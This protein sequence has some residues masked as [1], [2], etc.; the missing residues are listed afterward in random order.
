MNQQNQPSPYFIR[1]TTPLE[2]LREGEYQHNF[3]EEDEG[4]IDFQ[5]YWRIIRKHLGLIAAVVATAVVLTTLHELMQTPMYTAEATIL[6]KPGTP[7]ILGSQSQTGDSPSVDQYEYYENFNATQFEILKSRSLAE[8]AIKS[9]G[10]EK[11]LLPDEFAAPSAAGE[12]WTKSALD[13]L[14]KSL[15]LSEDEAPAPPRPQHV[16]NSSGVN[17]DAISA[18]LG[19]LS[20]RPVPDTDLAKIA[21]TTPDPKLSAELANAHA[22]A[23]IRQ[24]IELHSQANEEAQKFLQ[25]KL[26][27]LKEQLQK[28]EYALNR[29][30]RDQGIVPGL[31]SLDGKETVVLD[32]LSD[33]SK[34]LTKAQV[35]RIDL[36]SK[37]QMV[38]N[39]QYDALPEMLDDKALQTLREQYDALN[40]EYAGMAK[41]FKPDYPPLARLQAKRDQ[42]QQDIDQEEHR[43]ASAVESQYDEARARETDLQSEME[44]SRNKALGLND[45]AVEYA[46]LQRE[47]DTN[48]DL[49][50]S[51]LQR[52]KDVGL[53]SQARASNIVIVDDAEVPHFRSS[54]LIKQS[55]M[56]AAVLSLAGG[57]GLAFVLEF[58]NNRIKTPEE[59]EQY[60]KLPNLAVVPEFSALGDRR[61]RNAAAN[62][63]ERVRRL[64]IGD[65]LPDK[66]HP[67]DLIGAS[68]PYSLHGEAYRTLRTGLL[69]S[70]AGSPPRII[71]MTST[72]SGEG[73]TATSTNSAVLFAHT[74]ARVLLIDGDLRKPRCHRVF[75][76]DKE[77]GLTEAL[78]GRREVREL[79]RPTH[80]DGLSILTSGSLPPNPTELLGSEK[81]RQLL[82]QLAQDYDFVIIDSPPVLP[83]SDAIILST[84]VDGV[85]VVVN[86]EA[87]AKQQVRI[88]CARLRYARA[89]IFGAVLNKVN[90]MSPEYRYYSSYYYQ[91]TNEVLQGSP[92]VQARNSENAR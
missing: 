18:Y 68:N 12:S 10:L 16:A 26:V 72:T 45:A 59:L 32:R 15:G 80:V 43:V 73:K 92:E 23:Y 81:M 44:T 79:I 84:L 82:A 25:N 24:G 48:R 64:A 49:Y 20:I 7:Q 89:K 70:R 67:K 4:R 77:P 55:V 53:A 51:V 78:T 6:I 76:L 83:V 61:R 22:H 58:F 31:M 34:D 9:G 88:A 36:E 1:R 47:V 28:S 19:G 42:L 46:I 5:Q 66:S 13:W 69:Y 87:T 85:V 62:Q 39:H 27:D 71:L 17:P 63:L 2:E 54:P 3:L 29:Y 90:V 52:M 40:T 37:V 33:L 14:R 74:G 11:D 35:D 86:S 60:L 56:T 75:D 8:E 91:Y 21:F 41:Q 57:I 38:H 50:N 65:S 30:R